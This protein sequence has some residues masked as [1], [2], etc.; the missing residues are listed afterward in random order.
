MKGAGRRR[1][2]KKAVATT[3]NRQAMASPIGQAIVRRRQRERGE[4][5]PSPEL[6]SVVDHTLYR[7]VSLSRWLSRLPTPD[8]TAVPTVP[9]VPTDDDEKRGRGRGNW[10][11]GSDPNLKE[12]R[13][14]KTG[15][16]S[17]LLF[18]ADLAFNITRTKSFTSANSQLVR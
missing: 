5:G 4:K 15:S 18:S 10:E 12:K 8:F 11:E 7:Y 9:T 13:S 17:Y 3:S 6:R 16:S 2:H 14:E 1:S